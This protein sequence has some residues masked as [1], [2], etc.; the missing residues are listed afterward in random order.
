MCI[1]RVEG[2]AQDERD[3]EAVGVTVHERLARSGDIGEREL[4]RN[5]RD[6]PWNRKRENYHRYIRHGIPARDVRCSRK[7]LGARCSP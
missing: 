1:S 2:K 7:T 5:S 6:A 4:A 3:V